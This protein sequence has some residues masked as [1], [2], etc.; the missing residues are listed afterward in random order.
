MKI[1]GIFNL[2]AIVI[3]TILGLIV[4]PLADKFKISKMIFV[5]NVLVMIA[6]VLVMYDIMITDNDKVTYFFY[7]GYVVATSLSQITF[8][9]GRTMLAKICNP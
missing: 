7:V 8:M 3:T 5:L 2:C 4:L 1:I 6:L 9:L